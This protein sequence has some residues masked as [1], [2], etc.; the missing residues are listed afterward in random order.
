MSW[1][2]ILVFAAV[3]GFIFVGLG[4]FGAH[5]LSKLLNQKQMSWLQTGLQYQSVHTAVM[6]AVGLLVMKHDSR[7][8][9]YSG[10]FF[11]LGIV[12]F[13]G[14]LY[15]LATLSVRVWPYITPL[16]GLALLL[17]WVL[18]LIGLLNINKGANCE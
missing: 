9:R 3:S 11:A 4:A 15:I 10:L 2:S 17:A 7:W 5:G 8:L 6:L 12:L 18:L 16:G 1:R 14:S 13:S